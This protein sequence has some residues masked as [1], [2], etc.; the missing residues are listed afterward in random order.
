MD[1]RK[2]GALRFAVFLIVVLGLAT[3]LLGVAVTLS[4]LAGDDIADARRLGSATVKFC[5]RSGPVTNKGFGY[6]DSCTVTVS[7]EGGDVERLTV[8]AVF[9][10]DDVGRQVRVGDLGNHRTSRQ[11]VRADA[12]YRP[13]LRW[14]G[15]AVGIVAFVPTLVGTLIVQ[16]LLRFRR[17]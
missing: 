5:E 8:G 14:I 6:W 11:L 10:L 3:G 4:R 16:E 9:T 7:W 12:P 15:Y 13:W 17:R 1:R 2:G